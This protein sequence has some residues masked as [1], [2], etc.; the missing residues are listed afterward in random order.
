MKNSDPRLLDGFPN[1]IVNYPIMGLNNLARLAVA[2]AHF[3]DEHL[4]LLS[5]LV[6]GGNGEVN[7]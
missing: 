5:S 2:T 4:H 1:A 7:G 6:D 3:Q